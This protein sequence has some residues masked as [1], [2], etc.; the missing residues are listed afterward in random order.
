VKRGSVAAGLWKRT[1]ATT[2][3]RLAAAASNGC[4]AFPDRSIG[5]ELEMCGLSMMW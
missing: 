5:C 4:V 1:C 3:K 2:L